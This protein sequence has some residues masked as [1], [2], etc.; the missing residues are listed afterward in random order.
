MG[1]VSIDLALHLGAL[2]GSALIL[3][4]GLKF[5]MNGLRNDVTE[6]KVDLKTLVTSDADQNERL[7]RV[8]TEAD[9]KSGWIRRIEDGL[10]ELR[11]IIERRAE[12]RRE[13]P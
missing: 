7:A 1:S 2:L 10:K 5:A 4:I 9:A 12:S 11:G 13:Q 3:V 6:I 8:E